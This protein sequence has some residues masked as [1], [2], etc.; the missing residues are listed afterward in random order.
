MHKEYSRSLML[1][2]LKC[3]RYF[4]VSMSIT[5]TVQCLGMFLSIR[6]KQQIQQEKFS[7]SYSFSQIRSQSV[8]NETNTMRVSPLLFSSLVFRLLPERL[9]ILLGI[10][11]SVSSNVRIHYEELKEIEQKEGSVQQHKKSS[12]TFSTYKIS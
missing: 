2:I 4:E 11:S 3:V 8:L 10:Q 12:F 9:H 1:F 6:S 7:F 5:Y